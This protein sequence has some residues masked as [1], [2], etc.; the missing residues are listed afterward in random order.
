MSCTSKWSQ[1]TVLSPRTWVC[2]HHRA[3]AIR[4]EL[5]SCASRGNT[6]EHS[7]SWRYTRHC[8]WPLQS[9]NLGNDKHV[10]G[11]KVTLG[12][13]LRTDWVRSCL[14]FS[15]IDLST[16]VSISFLFIPAFSSSAFMVKRL[17]SL[18]K[19]L[20][21]TRLFCLPQ[22]LLLFWLF[23]PGV[24]LWEGGRR[25][26]RQ[27][28]SV[29]VT[30]QATLWKKPREKDEKLVCEYVHEYMAYRKWPLSHLFQLVG[31]LWPTF[32]SATPCCLTKFS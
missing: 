19:P 20:S 31:W 18:G 28:R 30:A 12:S 14:N 2:L 9:V 29:A 24:P 16:E 21:L 22:T 27:V 5:Y 13:D 8:C 4:G 15:S 26:H 7:V 10:G 17:K 6:A 11:W 23:S 32:N 1:R 3:R 25:L